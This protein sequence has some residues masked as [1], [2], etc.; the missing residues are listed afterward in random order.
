M[1]IEIHLCH[2]YS[3]YLSILSWEIERTRSCLSC[4]KNVNSSAN[5]TRLART[6]MRA[7]SVNGPCKG[8]NVSRSNSGVS[9]K[10]TSTSG[11]YEI[12][13]L[14]IRNK[15]TFFKYWH[16]GLPLFL[17]AIFQLLR[18]IFA[19]SYHFRFRPNWADRRTLQ[20]HTN[21]I[22]RQHN[23][24]LQLCIPFAYIFLERRIFSHY[25]AI[26]RWILKITWEMHVCLA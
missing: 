4:R 9:E 23:L 20:N 15:R 12:S 26:P 1:I 21:M 11:T 18:S 13:V 19:F 10:S 24:N 7:W 2:N 3:S 5:Q 14:I 16:T 22:C 25:I 17:I 6:R 8:S